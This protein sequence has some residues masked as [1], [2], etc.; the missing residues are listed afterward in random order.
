MT[1]L[2]LDIS[3]G[4][5]RALFWE[6]G[7]SVRHLVVRLNA[8]RAERASKVRT[9]LNIALVIDASGSMSGGKLD[10]AKMAA[11]GLAERLNADDRLTV[12]SFASDICVHLDAVPVTPE[13]LREI[14]RAIGHLETRGTTNL[15]DGWFAGVDCAARV[16]EEAPGLMARVIILSDGQA[17]AGI[18]E[19]PELCEHATQL[20]H[21]GVLT[22]TLGIGDGY[23]ERLLRGI[24]ENG[25]GRLHDAELADEISSVLLGE[26][27]DI[28]GTVLEDV[29]LTLEAPL[30]MRVE[31]YGSRRLTRGAQGLKLSL[32]ALQHGVERS[33]VFKVLCPRAVPGKDLPFTV[34]VTGRSTEDGAEVSA[35]ADPA[36]L[37]AATA[38]ANDTQARD[39]ALSRI[40]A[41]VW[42]AH[43]TARAAEMNSE[44]DLTAAV[45]FVMAE[46]G[47]FRRY[48]HGLDLGPEIL[49]D[50]EILRSNISRPLSS[51]AHKEMFVQASLSMESRLDRRGDKPVWSSRL[52]ER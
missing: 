48:V 26:L 51:R 25:G 14:R 34:S 11:T 23:D 40:V 10:A 8:Q 22:S 30:S 38:Q 27:E 12:V 33:V 6:G 41:K 36:V 43:V 3:A 2:R 45:D 37:L 35:S 15:S 32:G 7:D 21:R 18:T 4:F 42:S 28:H 29:T 5:D 9:P 13:N 19:V 20:R 46:F 47:H 31:P 17:N 50:L 52:G 39:V 44:R 1:D 49:R 24:A 16:A